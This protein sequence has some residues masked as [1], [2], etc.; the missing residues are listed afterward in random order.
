MHLLL[1]FNVQKMNTKTIVFLVPLLI[2][3]TSI[4]ASPLPEEL[5]THTKIDGKAVLQACTQDSLTAKDVAAIRLS[6]VLVESRKGSE[7]S[8]K[9]SYQNGYYG[10]TIQE[11]F[12]GLVESKESYLFRKISLGGQ[13]YTCA[14]VFK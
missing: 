14:Y 6:S 11:K 2:F 9:E 12:S 4:P 7:I 8:I 3:T 13:T 1:N 5:L 10:S